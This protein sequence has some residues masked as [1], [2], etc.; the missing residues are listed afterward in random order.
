MTEEEF[1]NLKVGDII[2]ALRKDRHVITK[3]VNKGMYRVKNLR[4]NL[5]GSAFIACHWTLDNS[6]YMVCI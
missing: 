2:I 6:V 5:S 3:V 1:N 4:N